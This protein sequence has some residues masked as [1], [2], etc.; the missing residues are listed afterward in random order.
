LFVTYQ[1]TAGQLSAPSVMRLACLLHGQSPSG[2]ANSSSVTQDVPRI[3]WNPKVY[4]LIHKSPTP[5]P[6]LSQIDPVH[7][8]TSHF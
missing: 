2:E 6:M 1:N 3:L 7:S 5:G 4:Y 8:P